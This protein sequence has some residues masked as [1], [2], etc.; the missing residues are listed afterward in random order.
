VVP[1]ITRP[2]DIRQHVRQY[3][4]EAPAEKKKGGFGLL[5][6]TL[7]LGAVGSGYFYM[8]RKHPIAIATDPAADAGKTLGGKPKVA[9]TGGDQGFVS[10][11]LEKSEMVNHNTKRLTFRLPEDDMESGL[12]VASAVIAKYKGPEMEKPVIRPYTP[13]SDVGECRATSLL[14]E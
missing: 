14:G 3:A 2:A 12:P 5:Y 8:R 7:A 10:L 1:D 11:L 4:T 9:F 13:V 6:T